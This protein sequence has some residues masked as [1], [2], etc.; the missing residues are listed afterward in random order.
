MS[1]QVEAMPLPSNGREAERL[2]HIRLRRDLLYS[3][4]EPHI[5]KRIRAQF[6][7]GRAPV[8]G[9]PDL[10][11]NPY[12]S[13]WNQVAVLY[14]DQ[15]EVT[16]PAGSQVVTQGL[17]E[18]G[19]FALM[20]RV[21]RDTLALREMLVRL[22]I[23]EGTKRLTVRPVFP[24]MV[25]AWS[26]PR[27]PSVPVRIRETV[28]HP[29]FG[30]ITHDLSIEVEG[31]PFYKVVGRDG[32]DITVDVLGET[33]QGA[34]YPY[35]DSEGVPYLPYVLYHAA[36]TG[37]LFD[38]FTHSEIVEGSLN[39][40]VLLT[41]YQH[42]VRN[43]A[44]AQ[45]VTINLVPIGGATA[46]TDTSSD[47]PRTE[48]IADPGTALQFRTAD[49]G[50]QGSIGQWQSPIDPEALLRSIAMYERRI[51]AAAN[52][53]P[54]DVTRQE[55][56][57]RSG[58]SLAVQRD[59]IREAQRGYEPMFRR[60]DQEVH[61]IAACLLNR[62][63]DGATAYDENAA[64]YRIAY[65]GLPKSPQEVQAELA[66]LKAELEAG[67]V[68]PVTGYR[69]LHPNASPEEATLALAEAATEDSAVDEVT[70]G[71]LQAR[72]IASAPPVVDLDVGKMQAAGSYV[73]KAAAGLLPVATVKEMLV[74]L[75]GLTP[76]AAASIM[77]NV[78]PVPP[79]PAP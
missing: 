44:W 65:R 51:I 70:R 32:G 21:S 40:G 22:D 67:H 63:N 10:T 37:F 59:S 35:L 57:V 52:V 36:E 47:G 55:A 76:A 26:N 48:M 62:V 60:G 12:T 72:G 33:Y 56:D 27:S 75:V 18:I 42:V 14:A 49:G 29:T 20:Q 73:E 38:S 58:Y 41:F 66:L 9:R 4:Q 31:A 16:V 71:L 74:A 24:D 7:R 11:A 13:L 39:I 64:A 50:T 1:V 54:P 15:P 43:A 6:G 25:E 69:R 30:W 5:R 78:V 79:Q 46:G 23:D 17:A 2:D 53:Q 34:D 19:F 45:R 8:I 3:R 68:G 28:H 77:A 61:R